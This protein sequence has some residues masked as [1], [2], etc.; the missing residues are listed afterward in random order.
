M[1]NKKERAEVLAKLAEMSI[2]GLTAKES[3]AVHSSTM[4]FNRGM[5]W[6]LEVAAKAAGVQDMVVWKMREY[7]EGAVA[8]EHLPCKVQRC[9][10]CKHCRVR[11]IAQEAAKVAEA[12]IARRKAQG[13]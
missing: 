2:Y 4:D 7:I 6:G 12:E 11:E 5:E 1:L 9:R 13:Y 10:K 8:A 3:R